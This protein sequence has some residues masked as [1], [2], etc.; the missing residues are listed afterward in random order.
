M[1]FNAYYGHDCPE[2]GEYDETAQPRQS[3][4]PTCD[5]CG[6]EYELLAD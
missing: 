6:E 3:E 1:P 5:E 2:T 4:P